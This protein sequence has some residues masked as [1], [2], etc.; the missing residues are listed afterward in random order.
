MNSWLDKQR[1]NS[2]HYF[3]CWLIAF[4]ARRKSPECSCINCPY[5]KICEYHKE[6]RKYERRCSPI[7]IEKDGESR[8][9]FG[10]RD[11]DGLR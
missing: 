2:L 10:R 9:G 11:G 6:R 4:F 5:W 7:D 3:T 1:P 8:F